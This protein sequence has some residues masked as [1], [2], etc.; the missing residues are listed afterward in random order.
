LQS[1]VIRQH[2]PCETT[3]EAAMD[4]TTERSGDMRTIHLSG[5]MTAGRDDECLPVT[6]RRMARH[7]ARLLVLDLRD[8]SYMDSTCLGELVEAS[9]SLRR[10]GGQLRLINVPAKVQRLLDIS[11]LG[12]L[13]FESPEHQPGAVAVA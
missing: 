3:D 2:D 5:R 8:V 4:T 9:M 6:I 11:R 1:D 7:G 12:N 10:R 13:L